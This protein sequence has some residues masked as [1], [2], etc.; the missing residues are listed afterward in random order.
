QPE[1]IAYELAVRLE[2]FCKGGVYG[3]YV[4]GRTNVRLDNEVV[5]LELEHLNSDPQLRTVIMLGLT[6]QVTNEMYRF[7]RSR[8]KL[9]LQDEGWQIVGD[10]QE[11]ADFMEE[12][13]RRARKYEG[14]FFF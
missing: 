14:S 2:P 6:N 9:F 11:S 10:D 8:P 1:R 5:G 12:G 7:D 13:Y 3:D 4:N